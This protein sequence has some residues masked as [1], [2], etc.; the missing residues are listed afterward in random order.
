MGQAKK[1]NRIYKAVFLWLTICAIFQIYGQTQVHAA[2]QSQCVGLSGASKVPSVLNACSVCGGNS[3]TTR[4]GALWFN[5]GESGKN[6]SLV[7]TNG[8]TTGNIP[9]KLWGQVY[10]CGSNI[11]TAMGAYSIWFSP[12]GQYRT[13]DPRFD[14]ISVPSPLLRG[15]TSGPYTWSG[16]G[17]TTG[18]L[19]IDRFRQVA[20]CTAIGDNIEQCRYV[21]SVNRCSTNRAYV[22]ETGDHNPGTGCYGDDSEIILIIEG[23]TP[24]PQVSTSYFESQSTIHIASQNGDVDDHLVTS[25]WDGSAGVELSTD[26]DQ[27]ELEFY[28]KVRY[29]NGYTPHKYGCGEDHDHIDNASTDWTITTDSGST[30]TGT[31][32]TPGG[33]PADTGD[34]PPGHIKQTVHLAKGETI[35]VCSKVDYTHKYMNYK[36]NVQD[37]HDRWSDSSGRNVEVHG[38]WVSYDLGDNKSGQGGSIA[39]ATIT[40]PADPSEETDGPKSTATANSTLMF[41]GETAQIGWDASATSYNTRRLEQSQATVY[42]A[43]V[44]VNWY[45]GITAGSLRYRGGDPCAYAR[46]KSGFNCNVMDGRN[47]HNEEPN[48][49]T[50]SDSGGYASPTVV[51]PDNTGDKYC[52][53]FGYRYQYWYAHEIDG[54]TTW[55]HDSS[56]DYWNMYNSTCRTIAK[57]PSTALWNGSFMTNGGVRTSLS[58]RYDN[59][60]MGNTATSQNTPRLQ[61]GSWSEYLDVIGKTVDGHSSGSTFSVGSSNHSLF[62]YNVPLTISNNSASQLGHSGIQSNSSLFT[63]LTT[64]L[65]SHAAPIGAEIGSIWNTDSQ[66]F[67]QRTG[68][69]TITGNII[70]ADAANYSS[71]YQLPQTIIFVDGNVKIKSNVTQ[72]DAWI[73]ATGSIDTCSDFRDR[74]TEADAVNHPR[75]TCTD[76]LVF[77]GPVIANNLMLHRSYGADP[78]ISRTG[79]FGTSSTRWTAGEVFNLRADVYLWA[80]A[81]AGR[82]DSSYTESYSRELAPRY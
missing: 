56:K 44:G 67:Y 12:S 70:N 1:H 64:Y 79:T 33:A 36:R 22:N 61:Y 15:A 49:G 29:Q 46:T 73:I 43:N 45:N 6:S 51:V 38:A 30:E 78:L 65:R 31:F 69:L 7:R 17:A 47:F 53:S 26:A 19:N 74:D 63:R 9:I 8:V 68:D 3:D 39:C 14:F 72:I 50:N 2:T 28:H 57:K 75:G 24:T 60:V 48:P 77:N 55:T 34:L 4:R 16:G 18:T 66:R 32:S 11:Q 27:I 13:N 80:Y 82:Y 10:A 40:R 59:P 20:S 81:Q 23:G 37:P 54:N 5:S 71:I 41:A 42:Q 25:G 62:P 58:P 35:K 52:N 21:V 76:Q